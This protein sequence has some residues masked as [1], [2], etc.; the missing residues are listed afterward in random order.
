M[1]SVYWPRPVRKRASSRRSTLWPTKGACGAFM[2][3]PC[4]LHRGGAL[5]GVAADVG[6]GQ[7]QRLADE[8]R[9]Q[10]LR[11]NL[12]GDRRPVDGEREFGCH[13]VSCKSPGAASS[14]APE[15]GAVI[16]GLAHRGRIDW[17]T[18]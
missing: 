13:G 1:S 14:A 18:L 9:Q 2:S 4:S 15:E 5:R 16:L 12:A 17:L 6:A 11:F 10:G 8:V 3:A 7:P